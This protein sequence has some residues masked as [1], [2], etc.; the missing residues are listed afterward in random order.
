[1]TGGLLTGRDGVIR[2]PPGA[3]VY[4][5]DDRYRCGFGIPSDS[6]PQREYK[7]S[8]DRSQGCWVCS[9]TGNINHGK[10]KHLDR[11]ELEGR[12]EHKRRLARE[13]ERL[14]DEMI[15]TA[16]REKE[17]RQRIK[18][19][20]GYLRPQ[21]RAIPSESAPVPLSAPNASGGLSGA[22]PASRGAQR[23]AGAQIRPSPGDAPGRFEP[24]PAG[25][26][27]LA[28]PSK[29]RRISLDEEG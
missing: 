18:S 21:P 8:Y 2:R 22:P 4:A 19:R 13:A 15:R 17:A 16:E 3:R 27:P 10:C 7:I 14:T 26:P 6:N 23:G 11:Y 1:M 9:C 25:A 24:S 20:P 28:M 29:L 5:D 12:A